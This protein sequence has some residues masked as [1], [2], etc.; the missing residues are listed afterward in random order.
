MNNDDDSHHLSLGR[1]ATFDDSSYS[2]YVVVC[3][4][5]GVYLENLIC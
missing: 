1:E 3:P 4:T 5:G 2:L